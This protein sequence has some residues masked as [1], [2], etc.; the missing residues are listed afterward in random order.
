MR[1]LLAVLNDFKVFF[2]LKTRVGRKRSLITL[3]T[4][5]VVFIGYKMFFGKAPVTEVATIPL[6]QVKVLS[7]AELGASASFDTVGKVE[8]VSEANLQ[9][10]S[11]GRITAVNVKVGDTVSAGAVLATIE[12]SA[13]RAALV[14]AQGSYEAALAASAQSGV[15]VNEASTALI[16]A[17]NGAVNTYR[18]SYNTVNNMVYGNI[19]T[20]FSNPQGS[21]PG[22]KID[23]NA[24]FM[25]NERVAYQNLLSEWQSRSNAITSESN[26]ATEL[27]YAK[28][29]VERTISFVDAFIS[30]FNQS[31]SV[32]GYTDAEL[33]SYSATFTGLRATLIGTRSS[34]DA[35]IASIS[36]AEDAVRRAELSASGGVVSAS[37]AQVKI[38]LGSLQ[39]A[40]S[41]YQKTIVR[42]PIQGVVNAFYLK[43]GDYV[44]PSQPA[45]IV[46][47]NN[48][49]QIKTFVSEIDSANL[50][51]G[52]TVTIEGGASGVITAKS[53]ALDP[54]TGKV[55][56]IVGVNPDS[57]L[58]N[59]A[60]VKITFTQISKSETGDKILVPLSALKITADSTAIF[61]VDEAN[62][63]VATPVTK[64]QLYGE[65]IEILS[66]VT[67]ETRIVTDARGLKEG[68]EVI[69]AN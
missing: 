7:V 10:E 16:S 45:G 63:L 43:T 44:A 23:G 61:S 1:I 21:V 31:G 50:N 6:T 60:T 8:A 52:D 9:T 14:Q 30:I 12:N 28:A 22:L 32:G 3:A 68:Q 59:G 37:D 26:L 27:S 64:G 2:N 54:S 51:V 35:A 25:N 34:I 36:S 20:F 62:K 33:Q 29:Q 53:D 67:K 15:G 19:D 58:T 42:S 47:N 49:L 69:I 13:Q 5:F 24:T 48:G 39:A 11:G 46:A 55:A 38:A 4:L 56:L 17:K 57:G 40:Q 41:N 18:Q 66:G 65:N